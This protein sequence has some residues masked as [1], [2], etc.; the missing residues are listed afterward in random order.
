M[1]IK[2]IVVDDEPLAIEVLQ[3]YVEQIS[4]ME[5]VGTCKNALEADKLLKSE[6]VDLLLLDVQMPQVSG[7]EFLRSLSDPPHVILTTAYSEYAL[8][9]F[10]LDVV[11]Y[12][13]K[14]IPLDR[15][16]KAVN[17]VRERMQ[18]DSPSGDSYFFVKA[19]KKMVRIDYDDVI[20]VEGLKDYVI[21][22]CPKERIVTLQTMKSLEKRLPS[23]TFQRIHRSYIVNVEHI[24]AIVGNMVEVIE[25]GQAKHLPIG[26]NYR[27][28]ILSI[29]EDK[30]L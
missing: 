7:L 19:D 27:D 17:R 8:D 16:M 12:L 24:K 23:P 22:R 6:E 25:K 9:G 2:T 26:K 10:D 15:F 4:D 3:N 11:D 13:L 29:I 21:I 20:Y 30:K 5:L 14:P 28:Q 18:G 1:T